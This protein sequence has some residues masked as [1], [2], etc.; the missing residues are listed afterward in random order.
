[1]KWFYRIFRSTC[2]TLIV[3][4]VVVPLLVYVLLTLPPVQRAM[5]SRAE[6]ELSVL[7]DTD[8][9]IKSLSIAPFNRL[10]L[11]DVAVMGGDNDTIFSVKMISAG[12]RLSSIFKGDKI[13]VD[14]G[15]LIGFDLRLKRE[16]PGAPLNIDPIIKAV[17]PKERKKR[18][19]AFNVAVNT[20]VIRQAAVNYDIASEPT[21]PNRFNPSHVAIRDFN[22]D[23]SLP[24]MANN[25]FAVVVNR[26]A[27][28]EGHGFY[29]KDFHGSFVISDKLLSISDMSIE[30]PST[31]LL[32]DNMALEIS[33]WNDI[34]PSLDRN[35]IPVRIAEGSY[36]NPAD[37]A[38]FSPALKSIDTRVEIEVDARGSLAHMKIGRIGLRAPGRRFGLKLSGEVGNILN[39]DSLT[40]NLPTLTVTGNGDDVASVVG[41]FVELPA[42]IGS[43]L[44]AIG[45]FEL[46]AEVNGSVQDARLKSQFKSDIG[47]LD[48]NG[49]FRAENLRKPVM[50][51]GNISAADFDLSRLLPRSGLGHVTAEADGR[52]EFRC[53]GDAKINLDV[54]GIEYKNVVY[55]DVAVNASLSRNKLDFEA[56][57]ADS[58]LSFVIDGSADIDRRNMSGEVSLD[59]KRADFH[60]MNLTKKYEG[61]DLSGHLKASF[62]GSDPDTASLSLAVDNLRF[63]A[64]ES[65]S[66]V[67]KNLTL[68]ADGGASPSL[69]TLRSDFVDVD[70]SGRYSVKTLVP[71]LKEIAAQVFPVLFDENDRRLR[72]NVKKTVDRT[73]DFTLDLTLK[74]DEDLNRFLHLPVNVIYPVKL[75]AMIDG[76]AGMISGNIDAPY[77]QQKDKLIENTHLSFGVDPDERTLRLSATTKVPTANGGM[78]LN[79][80]CD[81]AANR[82]DTYFNWL[83][84]RQRVYK[85]NIDLSTLLVRNDEHQLK[86][87]ISVNPS[88]LVFNDSV[89]TIN[90]ALISA[91]KGRVEV[92]HFDVRRQNQFVVMNGIASNNPD[93]TIELDL[94]NVNLDYIFE[95]LGID[96]AMLGGDATGS[97]YASALFTPQ[98][99]ITTPGLDVKNISY[100]KVVF[101][102]AIVKSRYDLETKGITLDAVISQPDGEQSVINGAIYPFTESLDLHF[103]CNNIPVDFLKPYMEAFT[104]DVSGY[105]SGYAHLFGTFKYIDLEGE[106]FARDLKLK[107]DFTNT[108]YSCTDSVIMTPGRINIKNVTLYDIYGNQAKLNGFV[109]HKFFK[110]PAFEFNITDARDFLTYDVNST[111]NPDWYGRIF[112]NG[113]ARVTGQP[114]VVDIR[115]DMNTA[116]KSTFTFVLSDAEEASEYSFIT[117]R[118]RRK[119]ALNDSIE[120]MDPTPAIVKELRRRIN[121]QE[122][123]EPS[124]YNME[125]Q[126]GITPDATIYLVMDPV[127][128]DRIR[129]NGSGNLRMTYGSANEDLRMY[130]TYTLDRGSYNFTLQDII[131]KDFTIKPGSSIAFNG[132]PF[133]AQ[134]DIKATYA[135][136][137]NLSDLDES[138]LQDKDL[139]R[140][141]VPVHA[142]MVVTGD[143]RQPDISFD[144]E[145]PT[146]TSDTY[147]KVRS[148]VST[149]DM[150]NRQ[151]IYLLA[152]NRFYTPDY[153]GSTTKGNELVSVASSTISSQLSSMLGQLSDNWSI[154]P[155][156]RSDRGDFSDMEFDLALS[157]NLLN[158]RLLFNGNFGYR[159]KTLNT[160]QFIGDFDLEYLL[161]KS[162]SIRLK[163]YNRYNDQNYYVK[164]ATTTQGIGV[165]FKRD[166]DNI[167]SFLRPLFGKKKKSDTSKSDTEKSGETRLPEVTIPAD[168][169]A[170]EVVDDFITVK[171]KT[172]K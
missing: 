13:V 95:S 47:S 134:L 119:I 79:L 97:F 104:S 20:V 33:G 108:V 77:L 3:L 63:I 68:K 81:G 37:F 27:F 152:L 12:I 21:T 25:D 59:L 11:R 133:G 101:G 169:L 16:S 60:A 67:M 56:S 62:T 31:R 26:I 130:G 17:S 165:V 42:S 141:N 52:Y 39:P 46:D 30:L 9:K 106:V 154:A 51:S 150:M 80:D 123:G 156:I 72:S 45:D 18:D 105:A 84:D 100:N 170:T 143:I 41:A 7:L 65:P 116:P 88:T 5:C 50:A 147:R 137:A 19:S 160:N 34:V 73:N 128:G 43:M 32:F 144:L 38:I 22:A 159:D 70:L 138:F 142:L 155:N 83:I 166:F 103:R 172:E 10:T 29:M 4:A 40:A 35:D 76:G 24:H 28:E 153:M 98:P 44:S 102:D 111:L 90:Q 75:H 135:V 124:V 136:N 82:L 49:D 58:L 161:N 139:N 110:E 107:L 66:L 145:F 92:S 109:S 127:G 162:G 164:T 69:I 64:R 151:I 55:N 125:F 86:A 148:I 120:A 93:D 99:Q 132:D 87:E 163:A 61:Y 2:V 131:I 78:T 91:E 140:T 94:L 122:E 149:E 96:K 23:I 53:S 126:V 48:I 36:I 117:L 121:R 118:D 8:V 158:N 85:G 114:G 167:F 14:Y 54:A 146:L 89:W 1:M 115:V 129:A 71:E 15:A 168:T 74:Y 157:S 171:K 6:R 112:G 113:G 57:V